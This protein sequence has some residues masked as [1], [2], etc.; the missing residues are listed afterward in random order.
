MADRSQ[1]HEQIMENQTRYDLNAAIENWRQELAAQACLTADVRRELETHLRDSIAELRQR[2][3][4][5]E[6][7]F[8]LARRRVGQPQQ[9]G[10]EFAKA[11]PAQVW[12][13]RV[14]WMCLA[15]FLISILGSITGA[16]FDALLPINS[17]G[18]FVA[19]ADL[20]LALIPILFPVAIIIIAV[21]MR[22]EK[23]IRQFSKLAPFCENQLRL[24]FT[25]FVF[26]AISSIFS[27]ISQTMHAARMKHLTGHNFSVSTWHIV[28]PN[29]LYQLII[30]LVLVWLTPTKKRKTPKHV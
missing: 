14:F 27:V 3:L 17:A 26:I 1:H 25:A 29:C 15:V 7:S 19:V 4:N 21:L 22:S 28:K 8:W 18:K 30:A 10:E 23:I 16:M 24:A 2:G 20:T 5:E 11:D 12:R 9:L 13:E 6:E